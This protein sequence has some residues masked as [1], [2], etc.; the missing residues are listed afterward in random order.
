MFKSII[1]KNTQNI[2]PDLFLM[3]FNKSYNFS[4]LNLMYKTAHRVSVKLL[5][6]Y[7]CAVV[8]LFF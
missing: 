2:Q 7:N 8:I 3:N 6:N 1:T 5:K 4:H